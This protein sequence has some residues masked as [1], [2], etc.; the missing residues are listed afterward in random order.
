MF[1]FVFCIESRDKFWGKGMVF[2]DFKD[3]WGLI[4][5]FIYYLFICY[6]DLKRKMGFLDVV[7]LE[8]YFFCRYSLNV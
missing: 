6:L 8:M 2:G 7:L 4:R 3:I 5:L 1:K